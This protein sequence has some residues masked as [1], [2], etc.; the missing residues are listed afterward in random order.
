MQL[1]QPQ[2]DFLSTIAQ[3]AVY[4]GAAG[5]GKTHA[6]LLDPLRHAQGPHA[7]PD[8]RGILFRRM[9]P[10]IAKSGGLLDSSRIMYSPLNAQYNHTHKEW[11]FPCGAKIGLDSIQF[12]KDLQNFQGAQLD[13]VAFDEA[14]QFPL[15][16]VQYLW[17]RVRS[18]CGIEGRLRMS[19]N[20]DNDSWVFRLIHWWINP[21]TGF[22]IPERSGVIR[23]FRVTEN[24]DF[25]W[26]DEPQ[27]GINKTTQQL[28]CTTTSFTFIPATLKDNTALQQSD[29]QYANRLNSLSAA[30]RE[31]FLEGSWLVP[32]TTEQEWPREWFTNLW[33]D[34]AEFPGQHDGQAF[35][36][37]RMFAIDP[38]KGRNPKRGDY[39]AIVCLAQTSDLAYV[40]CDMKRRPPSQIVEDLFAFCEHP[41]HRI[42]PGDLLGIEALQFQ[43][44]FRDIMVIYASQNPGLA[45][46]QWIAAGNLIIPVEDTLTKTMRIRRLDPYFRERRYR[47]L[48]NPGN[49]LL[50]AQ[51]RQFNG[52]STKDMHDDGLDALDMCHQ[53]PYQHREYYRKLVEGK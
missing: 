26:F 35:K 10:Q 19:C 7:Q 52:L 13:W 23:H 2:Y 12:E 47:F 28:D 34:D 14:T 32:A 27:Y 38:S 24:E 25:E 20:P 36:C 3:W 43:S 42:A 39:S 37:V 46:S 49:T 17:G 11:R 29:P 45:L 18:R 51:A 48:R 1:S 15:K 41:L 31:R 21:D 44:L 6:I 8:F 16:F 9:Y 53:L 4:G 40:D 50:L 30:E 5:G 22:P 33:C